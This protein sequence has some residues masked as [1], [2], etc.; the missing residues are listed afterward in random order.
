MCD[1]H[2][3]TL[4]RRTLL[5][6]TATGLAM[7]GIARLATSAAA[8]A[9]PPAAGAPNSI[10]PDKALARLMEGNGRYVANTRQNNDFAAGRAARAAAQ[11][12]IAGILSC[13]DAR[14]APEYLF[15]QA[16]GELFVV[17][18]AGNFVSTDGLAS[19]EYGVQFLGTPLIMVLGHAGCGAIAA[20]IKVLKE[21][22]TL[23]GH[24]PQL[25]ASI[26]PAIDLAEKAKAPDP[27]AA[28]IA[29]NVRYN[30]ERLRAA[31]P[32]IAEAAKAG[33][34]KIVGGVYDIATG[35]VT[36]I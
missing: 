14:V 34:I 5:S 22:A 20:T 12:P 27:L 29:Q 26:K 24:L 33:R 11:Y 4:P 10:T 9:E 31:T 3:L 13:A 1:D 35:R 8:A 28:A 25:V 36:L 15:D 6:A 17:R 16:P 19:L 21:H 7:G 32:I 23:P 30:V 18:V 2:G